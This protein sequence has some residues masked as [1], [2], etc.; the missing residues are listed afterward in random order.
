MNLGRFTHFS[1]ET[2][3]ICPCVYEHAMK[4]YG[5]SGDMAPRIINLGAR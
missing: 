4:T 3:Q 1:E 2:T 5:G